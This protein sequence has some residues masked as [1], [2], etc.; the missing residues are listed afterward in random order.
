MRCPQRRPARIWTPAILA[1]LLFANPAPLL[2]EPAKITQFSLEQLLDMEVTSVSK[3]TQTFFSVAGAIFVIDQE[4]IRHSGATSIQELLGMVP[5]MEVSQ[6]DNNKW[7]ITSRGFNG[8][9]SNKLQVLLDGRTI[10]SPSFSGVFWETQDV[11]LEDIERIEVIRGPGGTLWGANAV[12]GVINIISKKAADT[13][14]SLVSLGLGAAEGGAA[15]RHGV[16][17]GDQAHL[18]LYGKETSRNGARGYASGSELDNDSNLGHGGFRLDWDKDRQDNF[19][20]QGDAHRGRYTEVAK[21]LTLAAPYSETVSDD[22]YLRGTNLLGRWHRALSPTSDT[23]LQIYYDHDRRA[24]ETIG[25]EINIVDLDFQHHVGLGDRHDLVWG[26]GYRSNQDSIN[27]LQP[28]QISF[29]P[30][31]RRTELFSAFLQDEIMLVKERLRL[32]VGAKLEHNDYTGY[33]VQPS[34]RLAWT[35]SRNHTLWGAV[36]RAVRTPS[37]SE[38]DF[39]VGLYALPF[40]FTP[41]LYRIEGS[42]DLEAETLMDYEAGY[43][44]KPDDHLFFDLTAFTSRYEDLLTREIGTPRNMGSYWLIPSTFA[45]NMNG[46]TYGLELATTWQPFSWWEWKAAYTYLHMR[47][48]SC[49]DPESGHNKELGRPESQLSLR[50]MINLPHNLELDAWLR[51]V[52][53]VA[54]PS[55]YLSGGFVGVGSYATLDLRLGWHPK[56][57]LELSLVGKNLLE[58]HH[59]EYVSEDSIPA[60]IE[61][62]LYVK[63]TWIF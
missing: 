45:N 44:F 35:P 49:T 29:N 61:R 38:S 4:D 62:S 55:G 36:S 23:T 47:L 5:G 28:F 13:Q 26:L 57:N 7:A 63:A 24:G 34:A 40:P 14:G 18:R 41:T 50:S 39:Q 58:S 11:M 20:L 31:S 53:N 22:S 25:Q 27:N 56:E 16:T 12:N 3:K 19:T 37:R 1:G 15:V 33:E 60:E 30:D 2:A 54:R 51:Y 10:Y 17:I 8:R 43:R 32:T 9:F 52:D 59:L 42:P 46:K 21:H 48:H 6:I